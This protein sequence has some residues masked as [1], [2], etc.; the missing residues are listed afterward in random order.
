[1]FDESLQGIQPQVRDYLESQDTLNVVQAKF[2]AGDVVVEIATANVAPAPTSTAWD[3]DV[4]FAL[5]TSGGDIIP[6]TGDIAAAAAN[7]STAGTATVSDASPAVVDGEGT[8]TLSGDAANWLD[9]ETATLTLTYT[10]MYGVDKTDTFVV[11]FTA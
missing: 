6:Y 9:T 4:V 11:T 8:V 7:T 1:M 10:T 3:Y 5:K 2:N